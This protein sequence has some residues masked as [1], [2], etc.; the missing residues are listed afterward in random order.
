MH[1]LCRELPGSYCPRQRLIHAFELPF[2]SLDCEILMTAAYGTSL[3]GNWAVVTK[4]EDFAIRCLNDRLADG[5]KL[6][7]IRSKI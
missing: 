7:E 1:R 2:G 5:E 3:E 6:I 4:D